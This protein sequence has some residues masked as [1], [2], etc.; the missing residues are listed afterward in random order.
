MANL[1]TFPAP[2]PGDERLDRLVLA[3]LQS[4]PELQ[5]TTRSQLK[6]WIEAGRIAVN[7]EV[8]LKAGTIVRPGATISVE[9]V[10]VGA[11]DIP[12]WEHPL[13]IVYE[14]R[15]LLV[16]NKPAA[17]TMHPGAGNRAHT[18]VNALAWHF[19]HQGDEFFSAG[20]RPGI[21]HRLDRDTT[22]LVVVARNAATHEGL[23]RQF[24]E[25]SVGRSYL[26]L[27]FST[28]RARRA[29]TTSDTGRID[30]PIGRHPTRRTM[31]AV[32]EGGRRAVTNWRVVERMPYGTVLE[33]RLETGRTHQIRVHCAHLGCPVIGD[34]LYGDFSGLPAPLKRAAELFGR[35]ALHAFR[36][37]FT[38]PSTGQ[39]LSFTGQPP[40]DL[41]ALM[42]SFRQ[43]GR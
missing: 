24:A 29:V 30:A 37:E 20:V 1:L 41:E 8:R 17:L 31:M 18:L 36:L 14:D 16:I 21:V 13:E 39:R 34:A 28:P 35:Q 6:S 22:G 7:G 3:W 23:A 38:H 19:R 12:G 25:R 15:D 5:T 32:V 40:A 4:R 2:G 9:L 33:V 26:A 42:A 43:G 10:P 11:D 27:V